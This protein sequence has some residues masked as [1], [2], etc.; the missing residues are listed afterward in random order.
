MAESMTKPM[1][2]PMAGATA[3]LESFLE[4][5]KAEDWGA[6]GAVCQRT[7]MSERLAIM[8]TL[9]ISLQ[10]ISAVDFLAERFGPMRID[11]WEM[12]EA[13]E[14]PEL[15]KGVVADIEVLIHFLNMRDTR[16]VVR[17]LCEVGPYKARSDGEWGV[18]P[19]SWRVTPNWDTSQ[20]STS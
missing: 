5:W 18:N 4:A 6:M 3:A 7:W 8:R 14:I 10:A 1:A 9:D 15:V 17:V 16:Y 20:S 19:I 13:V 12:G 2:E 11:S